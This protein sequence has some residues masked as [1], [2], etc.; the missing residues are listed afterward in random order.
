MNEIFNFV[1]FEVFISEN[2]WGKINIPLRKM[3][4]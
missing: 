1:T 2:E 3:K 4:F